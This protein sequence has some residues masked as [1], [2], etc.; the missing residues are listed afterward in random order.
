[1]CPIPQHVSHTTTCVL[2]HMCPIPPHVSYTTTCVLYHN[3]CPIPQHVSYHN[4]C[5]IP[6]HVSYTTTC[7]PYHNMCP[8]P[9]HVSHS[10]TCVLHHNMCPT[11]QH[12]S[13][14]TTCV[15]YHNMCPIHTT[16][17]VPT[18]Y[19]TTCVLYHNM[20]SYNSSQFLSAFLC[21]K[22]KWT[23]FCCFFLGELLPSFFLLF[24]FFCFVFLLVCGGRGVVLGG[25]GRIRQSSLRPHKWTEHS[26]N[27]FLAPFSSLIPHLFIIN[28]APPPPPPPHPFSFFFLYFQP[29]FPFHFF[30]LLTL[31]LSAHVYKIHTWM[32]EWMNEN[33]YTAHKKLPHKTLRIYIH[34]FYII[35]S[36]HR[37]LS[38]FHR[39]NV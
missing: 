7:V 21:T 29:S 9:Q 24:C 6:Q 8:I 31:S 12:V 30:F 19:T 33:L 4:M 20:C 2:Y 11:P 34:S 23:F 17:C 27:F 37:H 22:Y 10:T 3:M 14:T 26:L 18:T 5:P 13:H 15:L 16:T 36:V 38:V 28:I 25:E 35:L 39:Q 1:M 32:N